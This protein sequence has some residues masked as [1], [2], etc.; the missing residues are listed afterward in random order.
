MSDSLFTPVNLLS[1]LRT[2]DEVAIWVFFLDQF[3]VIGFDILS[4]E[5]NIAI[6]DVPVV[7][8]LIQKLINDNKI[9]LYRLLFYFLKIPD[10]QL[11]EVLQKL[12]KDERVL[13][14]IGNQ[15]E[16][17]IFVLLESVYYLVFIVYQKRGVGF[18]GLFH[19]L[20]EEVVHHFF[21]YI[22]FVVSGYKD[23]S[24]FVQNIK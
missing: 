3:V 2:L 6:L 4:E 13:V 1:H 23:V 8:D 16:N 18:R 14:S 15:E 22:G 21:V 5:V 19:L 11:Y 17:Y 12:Y 9:I 24:L 7:Y 10:K 20:S